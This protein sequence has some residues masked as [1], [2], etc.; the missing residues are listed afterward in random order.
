M[1]MIL[2]MLTMVMLAM[3]A[4]FAESPNDLVEEAAEL[5][6]AGLDG[7][8]QELAEDREALHELIN[9]ILLPRFDRKY[10]E[11]HVHGKHWRAAR[12]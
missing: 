9:G 10:S 4:A 5:L 2:S 6:A 8:K 1:K 7:R 11:Q 3:P 12:N